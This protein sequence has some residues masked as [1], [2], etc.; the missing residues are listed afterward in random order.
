MTVRVPQR[1]L[2][3]DTAWASKTFP[4]SPKRIWKL[5]EA[6][7]HEVRATFTVGPWYSANMVDILEPDCETVALWIIRP[8]E[9][10]ARALWIKRGDKWAF[11]KAWLVT[12]VARELTSKE[13]TTWVQ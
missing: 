8:D 13:L 7:G 1:L 10:R 9:Q 5:A 12:P 6:A 3:R 11:H 4:R 2:D